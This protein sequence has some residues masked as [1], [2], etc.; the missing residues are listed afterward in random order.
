MAHR[1]LPRDGEPLADPGEL[2]EDALERELVVG[3]LPDE[4]DLHAEEVGG[5]GERSADRWVVEIP[6]D[7]LI[8]VTDQPRSRAGDGQTPG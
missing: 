8:M 5:R 6:P 7:H 4:H 1:V 2:S 3:Q